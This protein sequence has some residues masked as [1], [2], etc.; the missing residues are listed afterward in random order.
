MRTLPAILLVLGA[1][2]SAPHGAAPQDGG[3]AAPS[4]TCAAPQIVAPVADQVVGGALRVR[5]AASTCLAS[6]SCYLDGN[7]MAVAQG[8]PG[9]LDAALSAGVGPH[10]LACNGW[11]ASGQV[12]VGAP[13]AFTVTACGAPAI[14]S[15]APGESVGASLQLETSGPA[16]LVAT[17]CYLDAKAPPVASGGAGGLA[18]TLAVA[19]GDH[20]I[21]CN[22]WDAS[23]AV[24][25]SQPSAFVATG[26]GGAC[27]GAVPIDS[28][29]GHNTSA[30]PTY[31]QAHFAANFGTT[32]W[33]SQ[34]GA[35]VT[36]DPARMD[37]SMNPV[38]PGHV[39][40]VDVHTLVPGRPDL[41]WFAH[42]T[43]WF[44]G[45]SHIDI[46]LDN[47]TDAYAAAMLQDV[48]RRGFDG[49]VVDWYGQGGE[50]DQATLEMQAYLH[51]HPELGLKLIVMLDKGIPNLSQSVLIANLHYLEG[52]YLHDSIYEQEG[53]KPIVMFFGVTA[54]LGSSVMASVKASDGSNEVWVMEGAGSL[55]Q[56]FAD[57]VFDWANIY[58]DGIHAADPYNLGGFSS[59]YTNV[60]QSSKHAFG[61]MMA[62]FN[63]TLT[64]SVGWSMGKYI[65]RDHGACIVA[66][67]ARLAQIIPPNVTRMQWVTWSDWEE[68]TQVETGVDS[69]LVVTAQVAGT[70]LT[71]TVTGGTG[72]E[73]T[74]DH[75]AIYGSAD[76]T[77]A[78]LLGTVPAG[79]HAFDLT[80]ACLAHG[81]AAVIAVGKPMIRDTAS[82]WVAY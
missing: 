8:G 57:Q 62:G 44:G 10:T 79:T 47:N 48:K 15:P 34:A 80:G 81:T 42:V 59:F 73:S 49:I 71:W 17:K 60:S 82:S 54:A 61:A 13:V 31:D 21:S 9:A 70:S 24:Y 12:H 1:C 36:I 64:K 2:S 14:L 3:D 78:T 37:R 75:Y 52:Q 32:S 56:S 33:I 29:V 68:G 38:T 65:P 58:T 45:A 63:G 6:T 72:D 16:C 40:N 20:Q 28:L 74:V 41:R 19:P 53:G 39:S 5:T 35:T 66:R 55:S 51:A 76:G 69:D 23:G 77:T 27:A 22:G 50:E 4:V 26:G 25:V 67:A 43:P 46:G 7:P 30:S 11:E 18:A